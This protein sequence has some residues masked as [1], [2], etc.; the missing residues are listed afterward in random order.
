[1]LG[2]RNDTERE[3]SGEVWVN[4]IHLGDPLIRSG[5]ARRGNMS[6]SLGSIVRLRGG[7]ASQDK[8]FESGAGEIGRQRLSSRGYSTTNNDYN[9]NAD[10]TLFSW[11]PIRYS[12]QEQESETEALRGSYTT[13]QSGK[14]ETHNRDVS[15][16]FNRNPL[17]N[18]GFAYNYQDFWNERQGTQISHLYTGTFRYNIGSK[19]GFNAQYRHEDILAKA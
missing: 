17:P 15:V 4:E 5:W 12:I 6:V 19:L 2:I 13:F 11:L 9:I 3:I 7:Y 14:S 18:L 16:Q 1:M 8:D 10:V